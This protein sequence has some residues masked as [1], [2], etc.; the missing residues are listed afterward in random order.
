VALVAL[1]TVTGPI[2]PAVPPPTE[3]EGP[4]LAVVAPWKKFENE[5]VIVT[6]K[7]CPGFP[8]TGESVINAGGLIVSDELFVL[9]NAEPS[10]ADPDRETRYAVGVVT[11]CAEET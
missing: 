7:L 9:A 6:L 1:L 2:A 8:D 10:S 3:I 4:K 5:P 11:S